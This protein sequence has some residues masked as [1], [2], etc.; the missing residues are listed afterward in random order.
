MFFFKSYTVLE[1]T[2]L[3]TINSKDLTNFDFAKAYPFLHAVHKPEDIHINTD[4]LEQQTSG[5]SMAER[6]QHG[7]HLVA[8]CVGP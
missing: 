8:W 2:I 3:P 7:K 6:Q 1:I 4:M 5:N